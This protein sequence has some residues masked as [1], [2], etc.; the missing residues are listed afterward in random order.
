[1]SGTSELHP[2]RNNPAKFVRCKDQDLKF[3]LFDG[4]LVIQ[5]NEEPITI[6]AQ[7]T[8]ALLNMMWICRE[9]I[10]TEAMKINGIGPI[11][12]DRKK[13]NGKAAI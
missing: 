3:T 1:M 5:I 11:G 6:D 2:S 10:I 9:E 7:A 13:R 4:Q 8:H 12:G